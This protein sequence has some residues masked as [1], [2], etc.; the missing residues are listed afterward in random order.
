MS[1][2][3]P[4]LRPSLSIT[5]T[6]ALAEGRNAEEVAKRRHQRSKSHCHRMLLFTVSSKAKERKVDP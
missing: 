6:V 4:S 2:L 5:C 3:P 1:S